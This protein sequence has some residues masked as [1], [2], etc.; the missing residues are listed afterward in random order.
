M[1]IE[2]VSPLYFHVIPVSP[3]GWFVKS[4]MFRPRLWMSPWR[5]D[6]DF[7]SDNRGRRCQGVQ[8]Q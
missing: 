5:T 7:W 4:R 6:G 8:L 2:Y 1:Y 3:A